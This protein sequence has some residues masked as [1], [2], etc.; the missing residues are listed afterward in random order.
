MFSLI[1]SSKLAFQP[2]DP[3]GDGLG[4]DIAKEQSEPEA[5]AFQEDIDA[6]NLTNFWEK[7]EQDV[8]Q[9]PEWYTFTED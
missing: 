8:Q 4:D 5:E 9:D 3:L 6:G 2:V 7:V 1:P